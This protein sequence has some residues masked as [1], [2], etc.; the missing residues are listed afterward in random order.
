MKILLIED[1]I[2]IGESIKEILEE[3]NYITDW[4]EDG[5]SCYVA[6][7]NQQYDLIILDLNL[8]DI[9]GSKIL[10]HIRLKKNS[11]PVIVISAKNSIDDKVFLLNIGADDYLTKPFDYDELI[12][13]IKSVH[14]RNNKQQNHQLIHE[15]IILDI[16]KKIA[17]Y[18]DCE[19]FLTLKE[20]YILRILIE[21]KNKIISR[22]DIENKLYNWD[23]EIESNAI[24][25]HIH[26]IRKKTSNNFIKNVRGFGYKL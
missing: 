25:V 21:N 11:I 19:I 13:R 10:K 8:P 5:E 24:E 1:D 23:Q 3:N 2:L 26:N 6:L 7:K 9:E 17:F 12:A 20:F 15:K 18:N 4:F 16:D 14:R 22:Q